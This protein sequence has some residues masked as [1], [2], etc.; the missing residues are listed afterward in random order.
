[1]AGLASLVSYPA[2]LAV[3][4]PPLTANMTNT[5][6]LV[7]SSAGSVWGSRPEL[8]GRRPRVVRLGGYAIAGGITGG[9]LL[10]LTPSAVF[11]R[12]APWMIGLASAAI[13]FRRDRVVV[14]PR[15]RHM[16]WAV[17]ASVFAIAVYGGY[18]GAAAGVLLLA[19]L[20]HATD[21]TLPEANAIKNV[22]LG[23][24]NGVAAVAFLVFGTVRWSAALPLAAGFLIGGRIGPV[25]VRKAPAATLRLLIACAG[26]G[27]A[28][29]LGL[30]AYG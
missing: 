19:L 14:A 10:L 16:G 29:H 6:A 26:I 5:V 20:L 18:F 11:A 7:C 3:G 24:A 15:A 13:L 30:D 8:A 12:I 9:A 25:L 21:D 4:L 27:L 17:T 23:L 1:M 22:T 28:L 2:L